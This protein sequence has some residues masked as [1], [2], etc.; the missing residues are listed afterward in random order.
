[1]ICENPM[2]NGIIIKSPYWIKTLCK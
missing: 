1:M 2:T